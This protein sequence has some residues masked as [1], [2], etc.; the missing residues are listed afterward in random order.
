MA[1][2]DQLGRMCVERVIPSSLIT[3]ANALA[4][5]ENPR[6]GVDPA[7]P[8]KKLALVKKKLWR[9]GRTLGVSF[10]D[11]SAKLRER[12][13]QYASAWTEHANLRF[14]FSGGVGAEIRISFAA[15]P[16][17]SWSALGTDCLVD[18][19]FPRHQ[20][21]MNFGWLTDDT[22]EHELSRVM[23]HEFGHALGCIH[24]H[25]NPANG[26]EWNEPAVLAYFA[27][28]PN[29][30]DE[31][32]IRHNILDKYEADQ[33]TGTRFDPASI[34]LYQFPASLVKNGAAT[35]EN[36]QLSAGDIAFIQQAYP[37]A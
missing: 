35:R 26:I 13:Q 25:Q 9:P 6:N 23:V 32:A 10:L 19:Y 27:G 7:Q 8:I 36:T 24:E 21:T 18:R 17:S 11:G 34:M 37:R 2:Q 15:D 14:D 12:V 30:W 1:N 29:H 5:A 3:E 33:I 4:I 22:P 31:A 28:P 20:P 16:G